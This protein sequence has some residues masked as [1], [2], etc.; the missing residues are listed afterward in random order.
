MP[1]LRVCSAL[2]A[3]VAVISCSA[4]AR[5]ARS[6]G[7]EDSLSYTVAGVTMPVRRTRR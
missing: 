5:S 7:G 1:T 2:A 6:G 3:L 4:P